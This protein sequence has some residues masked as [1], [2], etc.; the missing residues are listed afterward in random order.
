MKL[1]FLLCSSFIPDIHVSFSRL[2]LLLLCFVSFCF[3]IHVFCFILLWL[4][5]GKNIPIF[6]L[7]FVCRND[8]VFFRLYVNSNSF[9]IISEFIQLMSVHFFLL[10]TFTVSKTLYRW[11]PAT[12]NR[13]LKLTYLH[14]HLK[15]SMFTVGLC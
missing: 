8:F 15:I 6:Y 10:F 11:F 12:I 7:H 4:F 9:S 14:V 3:V 1:V 2:F 13:E 5:H